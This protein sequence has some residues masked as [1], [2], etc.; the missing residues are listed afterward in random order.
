MIIAESVF[1][2]NLESSVVR[3]RHSKMPH[4]QCTE[5]PTRQVTQGQVS[6]QQCRKGNRLQPEGAGKSTMETGRTH[7]NYM[8]YEWA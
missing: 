5:I 8:K 4:R 2:S 3:D 7:D 1:T 6:Q